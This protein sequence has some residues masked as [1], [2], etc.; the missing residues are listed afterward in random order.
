[1]N[2][3]TY[4][5]KDR[6][7][8]WLKKRNRKAFYQPIVAPTVRQGTMALLQVNSIEI[9]RISSIFLSVFVVCWCG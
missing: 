6:D 5:Q 8:S 2:I 3:K 7:E 1:M 9:H 4:E